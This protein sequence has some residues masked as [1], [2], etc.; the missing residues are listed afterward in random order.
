MTGPE[1]ERLMTVT[2]RDRSSEAPW[3]HGLTSPCVRTVA[4]SATCP[5]CG[6]ERGEPRNLN[7]FDDGAYYSVDTWTNPC[8]HVDYYR[9]VLAEA[10]ELANGGAR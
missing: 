9:D 8:G 7:Q 2:V 5:K 3:G 4:I 6:G 10:R 1:I